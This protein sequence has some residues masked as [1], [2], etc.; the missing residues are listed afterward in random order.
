[1]NLVI[2]SVQSERI[3]SILCMQL[4]LPFYSDS[5]ET[6]QVVTA[7]SEDMHIV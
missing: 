7:W 3:L 6:L 4:L 5:F 1:M 2:F